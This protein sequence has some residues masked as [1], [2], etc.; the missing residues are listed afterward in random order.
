[1]RVLV[2]D[3]EPTS[4]LLARRAIERLSHDC[5]VAADGLIAWEMLQAGDFDVLITDW[6][7]PGL[8]GPELCR[9]VR[10][11]KRDSYTYILL[12]TS[13]SADTDV[14]VGMESGADDYLVKPVDP[15]ALQTRLIAAQRVTQL[16]HE[17]AHA[18]SE[19]AKLARTDP[20]T[21]LSNRL[22]LHEDLVAVHERARRSQRP[23]AVALC[24]LDGFKSY[25]DTYGHLEGDEALRRVGLTIANHV[26]AGDGAY[27]YGGEEFLILLPDETADRALVAMERLR[28]AIEALA[29][30]HAGRRPPGVITL[31]IGIAGWGPDHDE[32][33]AQVLEAADSALYAAKQHGRNR[34]LAPGRHVSEF[35]RL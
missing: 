29:I 26:R 2:A 3:D 9:R 21:Q 15:F 25:N 27:R 32:T 5:E 14:I 11:S 17:L 35:P 34:V 16:H 22:R 6:M 33:P 13:L 8:D 7:M 10:A 4:R 28:G 1:M 30:P 23:F 12:A 20:L 24:D 19:L 18:K 31:S